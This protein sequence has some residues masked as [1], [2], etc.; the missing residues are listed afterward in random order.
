MLAGFML[1]VTPA[2]QKIFMVQYR[3]NAGERRTPAI[4]RFVAVTTDPGPFVLSNFGPPPGGGDD[5]SAFK[6][7]LVG[8]D[9]SRSLLRPVG[10]HLEH[11]RARGRGQRHV[12]QFVTAD[13]TLGSEALGFGNV[14]AYTPSPQYGR[15]ER[16]WRGQIG[17]L[18]CP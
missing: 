14:A 17:G 16:R 1:K 5:L 3:T 12:T 8:G 4:G 2:G 11:Q 13:Q 7:R 15:S 10:D 18:G 6:G 9:N